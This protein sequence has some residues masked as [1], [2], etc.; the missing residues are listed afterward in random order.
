VISEAYAGGT[1]NGLAVTNSYDSL[2]RR[3][4]VG[5]SGYSATTQSYSY[6]NASRLL[7]VSDGVYSANYAYVAN[8][9]MVDTVT[10]KQ[11]GTIRLSGIRSYD[12]LNRL[13]SL[14]NTFSGGGAANF[15]YGYN[16]ANQRTNVTLADGSYWSYQYDSLGHV[17]NGRRAWSDTVPVA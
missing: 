2:L 17:T 3:S 13:T 15:R 8:A 10:Y 11:S 14:S 5:V 16:N 6:D 1:L 4:A 9:A 7:S 12:Y